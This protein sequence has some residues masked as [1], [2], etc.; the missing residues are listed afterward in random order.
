MQELSFWLERS[1]NKLHAQTLI[2]K[3]SHRCPR[4]DEPP[5]LQY[6][7]ATQAVM[8]KG[9]VCLFTGSTLHA[10]GAN[11]TGG[12][13][14]GMLIGYVLGWLA[15]E[16]NMYVTVPPDKA[17]TLDAGVQDLIGYPATERGPSAYNASNQSAYTGKRTNAS[18]GGIVF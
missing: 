2:V 7:H 11:R 12:R 14:V 3:G 18:A 13:R 16:Q 1:L 4:D 5:R 15:Q 17:K 8:P 6:E 9:S 10:G